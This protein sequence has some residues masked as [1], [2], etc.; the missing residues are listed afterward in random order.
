MGGQRAAFVLQAVKAL[1]VKG[2]GCCVLP[3]IC[4]GS[5]L[6]VPKPL[7][8]FSLQGLLEIFWSVIFMFSLVETV[9][10]PGCFC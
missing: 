4:M 8:L 6:E 3:S 7:P 1:R 9:V 10:S 5:R 2:D